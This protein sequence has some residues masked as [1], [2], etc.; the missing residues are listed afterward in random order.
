MWQNSL[1]IIGVNNHLFSFWFDLLYLN[2]APASLPL[3]W[4]SAAQLHGPS[5]RAGVTALSLVWEALTAPANAAG[6]FSSRTEPTAAAGAVV[7]TN[8]VG[9]GVL[10]SGL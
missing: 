3:P 10:E 7:S 9:F 8:R 4:Q 2:S 1:I 6:L 5:P